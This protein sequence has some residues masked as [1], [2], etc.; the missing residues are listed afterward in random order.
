MVELREARKIAASTGLGLQYVLKEAR[1]FD[2]WKRLSPIVM[3][4]KVRSR[5]ILVCK[6]G[7]ALNKIY[8]AG[9][10]RFSED[11]DF[12][13]FFKGSLTRGQKVD[14]LQKNLIAALTK[15]YDIQ[16]PRMMREVLRFTCSFDNE[17]EKRDS[18]FVEFNLQV[19][20]VGRIVV[21]EAKSELWGLSAKIPVYSF[22][23]LVAKKL[24]TFYERESGKDLYDIYRSLEERSNDEVRRIVAV[25]RRVLKA[26]GIEY[27][28]FVSGMSKALENKQ[29]IS[30]V[31]A[32]SNP[33]IPRSLR[34][35]WMDAADDIWK[36]LIPFL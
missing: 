12:D 2:I 33:Y 8:L 20:K 31:H 23:T 24:K 3:S 28:E 6:G 36:S 14:F 19:P 25:F 9:V 17:M 27:R 15:H 10:Q 4:R 35:N 22:E 13:A 16:R 32:S 29:L 21:R 7:T 5:A 30:R 1:V 18:I 11:L 34:I 26:E